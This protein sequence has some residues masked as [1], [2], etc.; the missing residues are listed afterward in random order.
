ML[1]PKILKKTLTAFALF[2]LATNALFAQNGSA[3]FARSI[4][5]I[6][7]VVAVIVAG[8]LGIILFL[9]AVERRVSKM[10]HQLRAEEDKE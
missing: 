3:D 8:F 4:G 1:L 9:I 10:E 6:Y 5:K 7:V 2:L